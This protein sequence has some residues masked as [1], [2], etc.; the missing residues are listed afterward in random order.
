MKKIVVILSFVIIFGMV[1][2]APVF[3]QNCENCKNCK[4]C[5]NLTN[6]C[7][8]D[9]GTYC[10][11][12]HENNCLNA[13]PI[14]TKGY[15]YGETV[16]VLFE[17][18]LYK[19]G[20]IFYGWSH[21]PNGYANYGYAYDQ[22]VMPAKNIDLYAICIVP[23]YGPPAVKTCD[24]CGWQWGGRNPQPPVEPGIID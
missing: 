9:L 6:P 21:T 10:V 1:S 3:A 13:V 14:D 15:R 23:Y 17:P 22:F 11:T 16:T 24:P 12:Y 4:N 2:A 7:Q 5:D 8:K 18:V 20:L 19:D